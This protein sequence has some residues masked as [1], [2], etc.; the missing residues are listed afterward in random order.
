MS[1]KSSTVLLFW[2]LGHFPLRCETNSEVSLGVPRRSLS[3][4]AVGAG[5]LLRSSERHA[6]LTCPREA[7]AAPLA[8]S[9]RGR[10][11][12]CLPVEPCLPFPLLLPVPARRAMGGNSA[13]ALWVSGW[14]SLAEYEVQPLTSPAQ[15][16]GCRGSFSSPI[17]SLCSPRPGPVGLLGQHDAG[18]RVCLLLRLRSSCTHITPGAFTAGQQPWGRSCRAH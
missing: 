2:A 4:A 18:L 16:S 1:D 14:I 6:P 15:D 3:V 17:R 12:A 10:T 7:E 11:M 8:G 5:S 13:F 9:D